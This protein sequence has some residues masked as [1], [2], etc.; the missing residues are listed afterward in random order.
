VSVFRRVLPIGARGHV[1]LQAL[2]GARGG[3]SFG[4]PGNVFTQYY[5]TNGS[6]AV[7]ADFSLII[8]IIFLDCN[9]R[10]KN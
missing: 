5:F 9:K 6:R 3:T 2:L 4:V 7:I 8:V 1:P 10:G